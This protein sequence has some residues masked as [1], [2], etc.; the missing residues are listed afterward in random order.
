[1]ATITYPIHSAP[2]V[3]PRLLG[4]MLGLATLAALLAILTVSVTENRFL[5]QDLSLMNWV[6]GWNFPGLSALFSIISFLTGATAGLIYGSLGITFLLLLGKTREAV[7]FTVVG[8]TIAAIS[9]FGDYTLGH[10][11]ARARPLTGADNLTPAFPS[12][13]VFGSTVFFGFLAFLAVYF[14]VKRKL[15]ITL[16]SVLAALVLLVGPARVYEGAHWPSDVAAGYLLGGIW[17]LIIIPAFIYVRNAKWIN[18]LRR[19]ADPLDDD[20][21]DCRTERS[22]ASVVILNPV[23]GTATKVYRP[24][25]LVRILYWLAFQA[26]FPYVSNSMALQAGDYRRKVANLLTLHRFGKRLVAPVLAVNDTGGHYEFVTEYVAGEKV[27]NDEAAREFLSQVSETFAE[28]GLSVWQVNPSNPHAQS[29]LIRTPN[30]DFKIIDLESALVTPFLPKGQRLSA[31]KAGNFPVFDDIDFPRM[32]HYIATNLTALEVSLGSSDLAE[33]KH[34]VG[35]FEEAIRSWKEAE[36]R[37]WGRIVR[38]SYRLLDWKTRIQPFVVA[39]QGA[40]RAAETF[41][42]AGI[43][44]WEKEGRISPSETAVLRSRLA[45][46]EARNATRHLG[47]HLVLSVA[48][49]LPVPGIRSLARFLWTLS[50]WVK[51]EISRFRHHGSDSVGQASN[52]HT[53]LVMALA[54]VPGLGGVAYLASRPLRNKLLVRLLL[55]QIAWKLPFNLYTRMDLV[56]ILAPAPIRA[57]ATS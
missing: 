8:L 17:L 41:F 20:C 23:R 32:R 21:D 43:D 4:W 10:L 33:L 56:R 54:L 11:V 38:W 49:V 45:S 22:I 35:H 6:T 27:E 42:D 50:F 51:I 53:P 25:A 48:L 47:A 13:H 19:D 55:D 31:L 39:M 1:M 15:L 16:V 52:I 46:E 30:G 12:G 57:V 34:S 18:S 5:A 40:E 3:N 26:P 28:A 44:R 24:P 2:A 29:N 14:Q 37:L 7:I 36:P 9:I